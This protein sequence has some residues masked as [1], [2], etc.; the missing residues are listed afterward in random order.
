MFTDVKSFVQ[1]C[2]SK[3][4]LSLPNS[5]ELLTNHG[6]KKISCG[7]YLKKVLDIVSVPC[8]NSS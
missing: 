6:T 2:F 7:G 5:R 1:N 8:L 3:R 4:I